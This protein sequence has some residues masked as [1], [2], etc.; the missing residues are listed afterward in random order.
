V[1]SATDETSR[2]VEQQHRRTGCQHAGE[3]QQPLLAEAQCGG[4]P[5]IARSRSAVRQADPRRCVTRGSTCARVGE[6][7]GRVP[8]KVLTANTV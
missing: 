2:I 7:R 5:P 8:S 1:I 3:L 6:P 4:A